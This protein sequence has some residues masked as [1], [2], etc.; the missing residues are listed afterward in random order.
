MGFAEAVGCQTGAWLGPGTVL[1]DTD[2]GEPCQGQEEVK[3]GGEVC[4]GEGERGRRRVRAGEWVE[5]EGGWCGWQVRM[6]SGV[7]DGGE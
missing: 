4:G 7:R 1:G 3:D 6:H 2:M 5:M